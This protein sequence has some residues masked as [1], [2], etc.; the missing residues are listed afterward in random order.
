M[1]RVTHLSALV[2]AGGRGKRM[3]TPKAVLQLAGER[4]VDRAVRLAGEVFGEVLVSRGIGAAIPHLTVRQVPDQER[5][6]GPLAGLQAG[7]R[8][9]RTEGI[10]TLPIDMPLID[11]AFL[12]LLAGELGDADALVTRSRSG[13]QPLLAAY[14][15][16]CLPAI[17]D[18]MARGQRQV[19]RFFPHVRLRELVVTEFEGWR[20]HDEMF[21][22][23]NTPADRDAAL[24]ALEAGR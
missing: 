23:V 17:E 16:R 2:L 22:N 19:L 4:L 18:T 3:G 24:R 20:D 9:V 6:F 7:L 10:V 1:K 5:A 21:L 15:R 8:A 12:A 11:P 14:H 13:L